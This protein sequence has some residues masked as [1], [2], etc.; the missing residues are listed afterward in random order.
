[1]SKR[2]LSVSP[3]SALAICP[4]N[5]RTAVELQTTAP[6]RLEPSLLSWPWFV[7]SNRLF[8]IASAAENNFNADEHKLELLGGQGSDALGER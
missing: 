2:R 1:V 5:V 7:C 8:G 4:P 6:P 3:S